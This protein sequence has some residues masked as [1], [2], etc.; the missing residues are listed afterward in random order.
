MLKK[1]ERL[2]RSQFNVSFKGGRRCHSPLLTLIHSP[3]LNHSFHGAVVVS[4]K[5]YKSAVKR[6]R[7]RRRLY[8]VLYNTKVS[9]QVEG[10]FIVI[11]KP[12]SA[13]APYREIKEELVSLLKKLATGA[14]AR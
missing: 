13:T 11:V 10:T 1:N 2:S 7:L 3:S 12:S 4:K 6:N 9:T 14:K 5:V 8:S